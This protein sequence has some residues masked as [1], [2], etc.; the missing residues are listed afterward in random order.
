MK[1]KNLTHKIPVFLLFLTVLLGCQNNSRDESVSASTEFDVVIL[2][3][4][5]MDPET[6]FDASEML[7]SK[8]A[9]SP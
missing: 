5:V 1:M 4:R 8:M 6:N 3:G 7:V 2:N 9:G